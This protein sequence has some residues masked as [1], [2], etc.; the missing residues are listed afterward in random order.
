MARIE[1]R[2]VNSWRLVVEVGLDGSGKR[3][4]R[5]KTICVEDRALQGTKATE[6]VLER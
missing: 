1:K 5:Y 2:G 4:K 3:K 6:D